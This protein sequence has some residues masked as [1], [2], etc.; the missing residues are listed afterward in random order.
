MAA[1]GG[2]LHRQETTATDTGGGGFR[3]RACGEG[4]LASCILG[5]RGLGT[6]LM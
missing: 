6:E 1:L 3:G 4:P 5:A 2:S